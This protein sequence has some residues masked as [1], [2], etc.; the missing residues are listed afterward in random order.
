MPAL[1]PGRQTLEDLARWPPAHVTVWRWRRL[2]TAA[3]GDVHLLVAW[4][5]EAALHP[6]PPP[7]DGTL[8]LVGDGRVQP[9]RGTKNPLAHKGRKSEP[10]PWFCGLR[11]AL[12]LANWDVYRLPG[13]LRLSRV[14][15][16]PAYRTEQALFR[17][18]VSHCG[19]P[20][21]AKQGIVEGDAA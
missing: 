6:L 18:M 19:P 20:I 21:G 4:W 5:V 13:A 12:L 9:K 3:Y 7:K 2:L 14:K 15:T 16:P 1:C 8:S 11:V 10:P 17:D